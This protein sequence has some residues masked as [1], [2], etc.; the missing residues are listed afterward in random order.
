MAPLGKRPS[1]VC[2]RLG[3]VHHQPTPKSGPLHCWAAHPHENSPRRGP[4][5][6]TRWTRRRPRVCTRAPTQ[7]PRRWSRLCVTR[8]PASS[9]LGASPLLCHARKLSHPR[10]HGP[11]TD[12]CYLDVPACYL[13]VPEDRFFLAPP[14]FTSLPLVLTWLPRSNSIDLDRPATCRHARVRPS[15]GPP[16]WPRG[17]GWRLA[18]HLASLVWLTSIYEGLDNSIDDLCM[19]D[20]TTALN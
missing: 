19:I 6:R 3:Q 17:S 10:T 20:C 13:D 15:L 1:L 16:L 7:A 11:T 18:R 8:P 9:R 12:A 14:A 2:S 4:R 5:I